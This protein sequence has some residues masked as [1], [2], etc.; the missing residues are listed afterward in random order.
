MVFALAYNIEF[1]CYKVFFLK[2]LFKTFKIFSSPFL[3]D[4]E[5]SS[6]KFL[7]M[8]NNYK[9]KAGIKNSGACSCVDRLQSDG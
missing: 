6:V 2:E 8:G 7:M 1:S 5:P 4:D 3:M 9:L